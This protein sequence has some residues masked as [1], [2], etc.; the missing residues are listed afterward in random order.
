MKTAKDS[1]GTLEL[2]P[3]GPRVSS[4]IP[5][6]KGIHTSHKCGATVLK[7]LREYSD[8]TLNKVS[9]KPYSNKSAFKGYEK[10]QAPAMV[11]R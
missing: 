3:S 4:S 5:N 10:L 9:L 7:Y 6:D 8:T 1:Y 11:K 2:S